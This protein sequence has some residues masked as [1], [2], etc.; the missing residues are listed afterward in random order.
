[1]P[2]TKIGI[3]LERHLVADLDA[4]IAARQFANRSQAIERA[5]A[6]KLA[7]MA[8]TRLAREAAKLDTRV[9]KAFAEEGLN[10]DVS[11]WPEY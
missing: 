6:E 11:A 3:T 2:K 1:M 9:E 5:L 4:L 7:R 10:A 8:R